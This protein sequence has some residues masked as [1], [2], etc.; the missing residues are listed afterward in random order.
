[1]SFFTSLDTYQKKAIARLKAFASSDIEIK[2][3]VKH[4]SIVKTKTEIDS[5]IDQ[6]INEEFCALNNELVRATENMIEASIN[7]N[8]LLCIKRYINPEFDA[9]KSIEDLN[10]ARKNALKENKK[11]EQNDPEEF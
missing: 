7:A 3:T 8:P 4:I 5:I 10:I 9:D 11:S 1:M 6:Y 2:E